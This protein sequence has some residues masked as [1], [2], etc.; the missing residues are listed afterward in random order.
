LISRW[1]LVKKDPQAALSDPVEPITF[2]IENT[3]PLEY[4]DTIR[5]AVLAWNEAF[6]SAGFTNAIAVKV[7]PDDAEWD[8]GDIRYNV[9]R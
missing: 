7:Q 6:E 4:R 1:S 9:L 2:W 8:A 5:D 3:T